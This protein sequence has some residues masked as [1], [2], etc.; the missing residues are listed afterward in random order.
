MMQRRSVR[1][2]LYGAVAAGGAVLLGTAAATYTQAGVTSF[3]ENMA[4]L[5]QERG[6]ID[7]GPPAPEPTTSPVVYAPVGPI[8]PIGVGARDAQLPSF[9]VA[10]GRDWPAVERPRHAVRRGL[11]DSDSGA[12]DAPAVSLVRRDTVAEPAEMP[13]DAAGADP[14]DSAPTEKS[15]ALTPR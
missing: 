3:Y 9:D 12:T 7:L 4:A 8:E 6:R 1:F 11:P 2:A 13:D 10:D 5:D 14:D 15:V